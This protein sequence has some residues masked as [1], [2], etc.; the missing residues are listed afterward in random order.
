MGWILA[1]IVAL[2]LIKTRRELK[3]LR[4]R[5]G[6]GGDDRTGGKAAGTAQMQPGLR[7]SRDLVILRLQLLR[8]RDDGRCFSMPPRPS[9]CP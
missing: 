1:A 6:E 2:L 9:G 8:M 4:Q 3:A 7:V 5:R